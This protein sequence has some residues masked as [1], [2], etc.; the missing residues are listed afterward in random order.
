MHWVVSC[1][2]MR[3]VRIGRN[4]RRIRIE[5]QESDDWMAV[6]MG[7]CMISIPVEPL[8]ANFLYEL[9][10]CTIQVRSTSGARRAKGCVQAERVSLLF[11]I[12]V[13]TIVVH[14]MTEE[15]RSKYELEKLWTLGP[16]YDDQYR[17]MEHIIENNP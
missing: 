16:R 12:I 4:R 10:A 7:E 17:N 11:V 6:E 13:G 2:Q 9:L 1:F 14:F 5:G 8:Y 3:S 15:A